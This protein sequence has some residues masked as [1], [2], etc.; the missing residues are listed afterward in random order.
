MKYKKTPTF[1][2]VKSRLSQHLFEHILY[3]NDV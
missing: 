3:T 1:T 2:Y